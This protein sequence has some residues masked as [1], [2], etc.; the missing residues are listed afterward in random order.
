MPECPNCEREIRG[1]ACRH[2]GWTPSSSSSHAKRPIAC[3]CGAPLLASGRCSATGGFPGSANPHQVLPACPICRGPLEWSGAC[4]RCY[5]TATGR[6]EDW[7]FPGAE[8][9]IDKG[10]WQESA[11][12]G[13]RAC[14]P[15]DNADAWRAM[16][17]VIARIGGGGEVTS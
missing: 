15:Q 7:T 1:H 6:R 16:K 9:Q 17:A 4:F 3:D 2:C 5:G 10:H 14:S 12:A 13:R 8:Y 11:P